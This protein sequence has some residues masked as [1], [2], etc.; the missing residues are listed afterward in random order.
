[1]FKFPLS[2]FGW[3]M[4]YKLIFDNLSM[5]F[6]RFSYRLTK[7]GSFHNGQKPD[8]AMPRGG[9]RPMDSELLYM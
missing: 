3:A 4:L 1:M 6:V 2:D 9:R 8:R 5:C 7:W